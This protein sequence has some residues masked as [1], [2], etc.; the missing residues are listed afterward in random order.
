MRLGCGLLQV[1]DD[2]ALNEKYITTV[3]EP[4]PILGQYAS[5]IARSSDFLH[6]R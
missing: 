1:V 5:D 3:Y 4:T 2:E 6:S